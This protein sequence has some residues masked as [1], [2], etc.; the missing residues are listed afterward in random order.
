MPF[1]KPE[2]RVYIRD[3]VFEWLPAIVK[4]VDE[5]RAQV[6][7]DLPEDWSQT[8]VIPKD[9]SV[10]TNKERWILLKDY[11]NHCLPLRN[12]RI[13]RDMAELEHLHEA[14]I[15]Y[16]VK[17]RHCNLERP[18][19]RVGEIIVAVNPCFWISS[20]YSKE[21]QKFYIDNFAKPRM[22]DGKE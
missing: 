6:Q 3:D 13:C 4:E 14:A 8:T 17:E 16:Q 11:Y 15:L 9:S 10:A 22:K 1:N 20:L 12:A 21:R 7:I 5:D 2:D 19:T 18:Y